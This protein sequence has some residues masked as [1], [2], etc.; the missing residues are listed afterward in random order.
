MPSISTNTISMISYF[1]DSHAIQYIAYEKTAGN[2][3]V[4]GE[5]GFGEPEGSLGGADGMFPLPLE[6]ATP[7]A[8]ECTN[9]FV[10]FGF[11]TTHIA[12]AACRMEPTAWQAGQSLGQVAAEA[13]KNNRTFQD[14]ANYP[15]ARTALL[16][17]AFALSNETVPVLAQT[18]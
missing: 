18:T 11:S 14:A 9:G 2:W 8:S 1:M 15:A 17:N 13:I 4:A 10:G 3:I 12:F 16:A 6:I 5:G 7:V